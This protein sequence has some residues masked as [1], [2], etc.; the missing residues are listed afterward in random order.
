M[1]QVLFFAQ[2]RELL[3]TAKVEVAA[4]GVSNT[5]QLRAALA[6]KDEKWAK[7]L[8]SDKLLVAVNQTMSSW[9][10]AVKDGDEVAFFPPVTGG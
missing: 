3:G 9:D 5:E 1:I 7:V 8:T 6:A 2:V 10:A 4:D